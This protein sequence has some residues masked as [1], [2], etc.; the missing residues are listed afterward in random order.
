MTVSIA[1]SLSGQENIDVKGIY[2][3]GQSDGSS[4]KLRWLYHDYATWTAA[5][6]QGVDLYRMVYSRD[7]VILPVEDQII[8]RQ[9]LLSAAKPL[10][11]G[12]WMLT[13]PEDSMSMVV[14]SILYD[15]REMVASDV[16]TFADAVRHTEINE[17]R[18]FFY[19]YIADQNMEM[20]KSMALGYQ[21]DN[22]VDG[23]TY[24]YLVKIA[25]ADPM[26]LTKSGAT[27]T[28]RADIAILPQPTGLIAV[29]QGKIVTLQWDNE[30]ISDYY[31]GYHIYRSRDSV[32]YTEIT[33]APYVFGADEDERNVVGYY[34]DSVRQH[35]VTYYYRMQGANPFGAMGPMS[36]VT[37]VV[38]KPDPLPIQLYLKD[39]DRSSGDLVLDWG[40]LKSEYNNDIRGYNVY[41]SSS[42][43]GPYDKINNGLINA[44]MR[45]YTDPAPQAS[46]YY[47]VEA[48][49]LYDHIYRSPQK[50]MQIADTIPPAI[51]VGLRGIADKDDNITLV[52][53]P[54][55]ESDVLGYRIY[56]CF[57]PNGR[58]GLVGTGTVVDTMLVDV[59]G[60][61]VTTDSI[62][63]RIEAYDITSNT[64][65]YSEPIAI[66]RADTSPPAPPSLYKAQPLPL[67]VAIAWRYSPTDDVAYHALLRK[68]SSAPGWETL[69]KI[70]P[71][72]QDQYEVADPNSITATCWIDTTT[73]LPRTYDYQFVAYDESGNMASSSSLT[74]RPYSDVVVGEIANF[75]VA[76]Q[77]DN[78]I[79]SIDLFW[80][81][82]VDD[83]LEG[84]MIYRS[85]NGSSIKHYK[86]LDIDYFSVASTGRQDLSFQDTEVSEGIQY[87]YKVI[88]IHALD[89]RSE[90]S[91]LLTLKL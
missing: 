89:I 32:N 36:D 46:A 12:Q 87:V 47:V 5:V 19:L 28:S 53:R 24:I 25:N 9:Q 7:G 45:K 8:T 29:S 26:D 56:K 90:A 49:D 54:N 50:M 82:E 21:D 59:L 62:Y 55:T 52:W 60:D 42:I 78:G 91:P 70:A 31:T 76:G 18:L 39:M 43:A 3:K 33:E 75:D 73:L 67:G 63:Y 44:S 2:V 35:G 11:Q 51:P 48:I 17:N 65:G 10:S 72:Q 69:L 13:Y 23:E 6:T 71:Y 37:A 64:S 15:D 58:F 61:N 4:I 1:L 27:I 38:A 85:R 41:K 16:A 14:E 77:C 57:T 22:L 40:D 20:A 88:A 30:S 68:P 79:C 80:S 34:R 83:T 86:T 84:F 81:Y 66:K 74:V